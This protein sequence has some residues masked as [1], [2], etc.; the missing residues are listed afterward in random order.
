MSESLVF[1]EAQRDLRSFTADL[2]KRVLRWLAARMPAGVNSD[3]LTGLGF[4][5]MLAGGAA[6]AEYLRILKLRK[7][8]L[9]SENLRNS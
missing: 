6:Y 9:R 5:A 8:G 1:H 2:E 4:A 7:G 3:H